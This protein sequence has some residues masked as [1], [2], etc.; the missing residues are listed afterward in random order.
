LAAWNGRAEIV[1]VFLDADAG[2]NGLLHVKRSESG[3][4]VGMRARF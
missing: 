3:D 2:M 1:P 4:E